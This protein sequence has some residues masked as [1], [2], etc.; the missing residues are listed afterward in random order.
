[1]VYFLSGQ[2]DAGF[3]CRSGSDAKQP[4]ESARG[5]AG[6]CPT[7]YYCTQGKNAVAK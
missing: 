5:D 2:C 6:V 4:S 3:Y 1:M 7:G